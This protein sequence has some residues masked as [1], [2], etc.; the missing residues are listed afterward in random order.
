MF[1]KALEVAQT[2]GIPENESN[3]TVPDRPMIAREY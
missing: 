1:Q 2:E 3:A